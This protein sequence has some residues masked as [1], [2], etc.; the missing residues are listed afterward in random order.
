MTKNELEELDPI[1]IMR[2][3][4]NELEEM[5][6]ANKKTLEELQATQKRVK[7]TLNSLDKTQTHFLDVVILK[8]NEIEEN[9]KELLTEKGNMIFIRSQFAESDDRKLSEFRKWIEEKKISV[10]LSTIR[11]TVDK[12]EKT[13][14]LLKD[15]SKYRKLIYKIVGMF[16]LTFLLLVLILV[17]I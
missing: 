14:E 3:L 5:T 2:S 17:G 11:P 7:E 10:D 13:V 4:K 15:F 16:C 1:A 12:I 9:R 6:N 8:M